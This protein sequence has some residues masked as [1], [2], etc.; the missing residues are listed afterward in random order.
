MSVRLKLEDGSD[1]L[2][3]TISQRDDAGKVVGRPSVSV[4]GS[5]EEAKQ[6]AKTLARSL[7]LKVYGIVDKTSVE[8][9][10]QPWLVPGVGNTL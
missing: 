1:G 3:A 7:G 4:V 5:K 6:K 8:E 2:V 9:T 10:P